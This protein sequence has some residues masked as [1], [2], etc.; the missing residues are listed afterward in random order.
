MNTASWFRHMAAKC[1]R[2]AENVN[3]RD[4]GTLRQLAIEYD[5][6]AVAAEQRERRKEIAHPAA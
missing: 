3:E 5:H 4:A 6:Q 1:R 2:L